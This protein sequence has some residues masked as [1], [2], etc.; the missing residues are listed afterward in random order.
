MLTMKIKETAIRWVVALMFTSMGALVVGELAAA[1]SAVTASPPWFIEITSNCDAG[2]TQDCLS[3]GIA[4]QRG[5][6]KGKKIIKDKEKAKYYFN[7]AVKAG[8]QN[9]SQGDSL[10]C[11]TIGILYFEG[12]GII[13]T[14]IP[15]GLEFLQRSC[16]A[17]HKE[18]C[19]WLDNSGLQM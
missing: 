13:P 18:A 4:L 1:E 7:K 11:Y 16:R 10:D 2:V 3:A 15:R 19:S 14:N 9:C 8:E 12:G 17:G 6:L 5:Q